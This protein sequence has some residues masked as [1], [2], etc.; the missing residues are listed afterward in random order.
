MRRLA[1]RMPLTWVVAWRYMVGQ[2]SKLLDST[3]RAAFVATTMG[4]TAMVIALALMTGYSEDLEQ[5]L[6]GLQAE[7]HALP[8]DSSI[9]LDSD[10][11]LEDVAQLPGVARLGR[12]AY[13]SGA[14]APGGNGRDND[15][16]IVFLRGVDA[17][18]DPT[19][20]HP[21]RLAPDE[22]GIPGVMLGTELG[23]SLDLAEGDLVRLVVLDQRGRRP[24]FRYRSVRVAGTFSIGFAEFDS[25]WLVLE[26]T[27]L[28]A[29]HG[30]MGTE[31]IELH[32]EPDTDAEAVAAA[33]GLV[34]GN[35]YIVQSPRALNRELF[36]ALSL[37][38]LLL[39]LVLGL[40]VVV[41]TF[42]IVSTLVIL[43]RERMRDIGVLG[44]LGLE[45]RQLWTVFTSYGLLLGSLGTAAGVTIGTL[46]SW[47]LTRFELIRFGPEV[48]AIY[49]IDSVPFRTEVLDLVAVV[50]FSLLVTLAACSLP[51]YRAASMVPSDALRY[52]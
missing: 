12:V 7:I 14:L 5:K 29:L 52:E 23:R 49:F 30:A 28:Q 24:R 48:A 32:L 47:I 41:S 35:D 4:V 36:Q 6:L 26:R 10:P 3:A 8:I 20:D 11:R 21:A 13:G 25:S 17:A 22:N 39:F 1:S 33:A 37:Q 34:L 18:S 9:D 50:S 42:N 15:E 38:K 27:V 19:I 43:V 45:P 46:A 51:A 44:A 2:R 40:I 16:V 31:F